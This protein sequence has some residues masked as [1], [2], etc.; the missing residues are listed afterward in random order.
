MGSFPT[1]SSLSDE[2]ESRSLLDLMLISFSDKPNVQTQRY[3]NSFLVIEI[4]IS[5]DEYILY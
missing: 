3:A 2:K 1:I 5:V 4:L